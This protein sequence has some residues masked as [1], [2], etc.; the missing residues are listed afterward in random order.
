LCGPVSHVYGHSQHGEINAR[1]LLD[2]VLPLTQPGDEH[3]LLLDL[4]SWTT[5][6]SWFGD[7]GSL[8]VWMRQTDLQTRDC[9]KA[10]CLI[11]TD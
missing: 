4:E 8:E 5:L 6:E 3:R 7:A 10:W 11:R 9:T 2:E 1:A